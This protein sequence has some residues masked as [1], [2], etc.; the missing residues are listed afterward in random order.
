VKDAQP[1][2]NSKIFWKEKYKTQ[3]ESYEKFYCANRISVIPPTPS[4]AI[5]L[6]AEVYEPEYQ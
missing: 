5:P 1:Q 6:V 3:V 2:T 4:L